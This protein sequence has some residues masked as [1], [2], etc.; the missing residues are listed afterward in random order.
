MSEILTI[1]Q[2]ATWLLSFEWRNAEGL[3]IDLAN[4]DTNVLAFQ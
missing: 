1:R 4:H 3:P 2:G